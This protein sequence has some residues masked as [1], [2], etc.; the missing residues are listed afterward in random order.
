M[1]ETWPAGAAGPV[2]AHLRPLLDAGTDTIVLACTHYLFLEDAIAQVAGDRVTIVNPA[3]AVARQTERVALQMHGTGST[4][5]LTTGDPERL[6]A[7]VGRLLGERV[8][9]SAIR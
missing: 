4:L 6:A 8:T 2:A 9:A 1:E 3:L 5:Y 7:Q